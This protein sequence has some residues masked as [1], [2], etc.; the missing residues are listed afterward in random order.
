MRF[1]GVVFL[2]H[3]AVL[4]AAP[5]QCDLFPG[6]QGSSLT[7]IAGVLDFC[8]EPAPLDDPEARERLESELLLSVSN[9][10]QTILWLKRAGRYFPHIEALLASEAVP[11][12]LKYI[13]VVESALRPHAGS[14]KGAVGFWQFIAA[15]G[16]KYGLRINARVDERRSLFAST[17]AA[18]RY[19]QKLH[20]LF[21]SWTLAAAAYNMGERGLQAAIQEQGIRN[22]YRLYLP[23][24]TQRFVFRILAVKAILSDPVRFGIPMPEPSPPLLFDRVRLT[25]TGETPI[26]I[27]AAAAGTDFKA[28]KDLNPAVRGHYLSDGRHALLIPKGAAKGF[29][30]RFRDLFRQYAATR[31]QSVYIVKKGDTLTGIA[32]RFKVPLISLTRWNRLDPRKPIHPGQPLVIEGQ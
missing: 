21:G 18:A 10:A 30:K 15:T 16:R 19:L 1:L 20:Q 7:R 5:A 6:L 26:R 11:E 28:I 17:R 3:L 14:S 31:Q 24:E 13:A 22:Y 29:Q 2:L 32:A 4:I 23:L 12:D 27:V 25:C 8:G 9:R